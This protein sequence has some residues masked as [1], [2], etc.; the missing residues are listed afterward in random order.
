MYPAM[1]NVPFAAGVS[2]AVHAI[3]GFSAW[4]EEDDHIDMISDWDNVF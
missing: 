1:V 2:M 4:T 3:L